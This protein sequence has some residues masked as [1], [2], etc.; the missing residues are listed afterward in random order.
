[1]NPAL[2]QLGGSAGGSY[3]SAGGGGGIENTLQSMSFRVNFVETWNKFMDKLR[4]DDLISDNEM[5]LYK[6]LK[7]TGFDDIRLEPLLP[8]S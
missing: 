7:L 2:P 1:M 8:V 5:S 6:C 3:S 4:Y